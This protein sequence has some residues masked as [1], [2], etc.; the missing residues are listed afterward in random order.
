MAVLSLRMSA[1]SKP[2]NR[3]FIVSSATGVLAALAMVGVYLGVLSV[4]QSPAHAAEQ[5]VADGVWVALVALGFGIQIGL[6][7]YLRLLIQATRAA[8]A[9][10]V[11]GMGTGTSTLGMLACCAH[12]L[13]DIAPL[14]GLAGASGLSDA[15]G[16]FTE[17]KYTFI[18]LGLVMNVVGIVVTLRTLEK[19]KR[20][21][22]SMVAAEGQ[23]ALACH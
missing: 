11:T 17:W 14:V 8:G 22:D 19:S 16:F 10:A 12:H 23:P 9:T 18:A 21:L 4:L 20:H 7:A 1:V 6:Y 13:A 2:S 15:I 5:L 3:R